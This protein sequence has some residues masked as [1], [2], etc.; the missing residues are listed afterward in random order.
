MTAAP[1]STGAAAHFK[2]GRHI[3]AGNPLSVEFHSWI[4]K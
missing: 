3:D 4:I 1:P 2:Q